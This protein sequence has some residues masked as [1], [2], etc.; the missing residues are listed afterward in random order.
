MSVMF[1]VWMGVG[2][3]TG[4]GH[5]VAVWRTTRRGAHAGWGLPWR[6]PLV[7]VTLVIA[8]LVGR[9]VPAAI[10]WAGGLAITGVVLL[11]SQR[12]WI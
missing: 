3:A 5:A 7:G 11:A 12:R 2:A 10:G 6:L 9:L 4:V 8:A 1:V